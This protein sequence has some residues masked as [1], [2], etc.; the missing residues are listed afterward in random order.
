MVTEKKIRNFLIPKFLPSDAYISKNCLN[1]DFFLKKIYGLN[2][3]YKNIL[4]KQMESTF[5]ITPVSTELYIK[6]I[7]RYF[8]FYIPKNKDFRY[9]Y[10]AHL[11]FIFFI[12]LYKS[13]RHLLNL[14]VR[15]QRT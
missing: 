14:P 8:R 11:Y 4:K 15:G 2:N 3:L 5:L 9:R 7:I 1:L 6:L 10:Y 12:R 13:Y